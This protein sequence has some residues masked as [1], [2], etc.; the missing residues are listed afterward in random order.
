MIDSQDLMGKSK[1]CE[2]K[3]ASQLN[4]AMGHRND[5]TFERTN[6]LDFFSLK[7]DKV[8]TDKNVSS[9]SK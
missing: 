1:P 8:V 3:V 7:E 9:S 2:I 4:T 5:P 6:S